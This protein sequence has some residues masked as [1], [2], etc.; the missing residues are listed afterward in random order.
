MCSLFKG[1]PAWDTPLQLT[2]SG[3]ENSIVPISKAATPPCTVDQL[4]WVDHPPGAPLFGLE[5]RS[6]RSHTEIPN[7][8][9]CPTSATKDLE[10]CFRCGQPECRCTW[11]ACTRLH[12]HVT[13]RAMLHCSPEA[14]TVRDELIQVKQIL[15]LHFDKY[16]VAYFDQEINC[17]NFQSFFYCTENPSSGWSCKGYKHHRPT[18]PV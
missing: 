16:P 3:T 10:F 14:A 17:H 4:Q 18:S 2:G 5:E 1:S 6:G 15:L 7:W 8:I 12:L 11:W 13:L 9:S